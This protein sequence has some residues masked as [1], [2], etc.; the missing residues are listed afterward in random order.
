MIIPFVR[1]IAPL[2]VFAAA[3]L[4]LA[5]CSRPAPFEFTTTTP[6]IDLGSNAVVEVRLKNNVSGTFVNDAVITATRLDMAPDGMEAMASKIVPQASGEPGVFR[7]TAD[8]RMAGQWQLS[9]AAHVP[10]EPTPVQGSV[11][12]NVE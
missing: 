1:R 11:V 8:F 4:G 9:L 7:F 12:I 5:A 2:A 3:L 6:T 10:G